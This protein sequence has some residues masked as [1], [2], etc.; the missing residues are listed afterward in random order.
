M[1]QLTK[2]FYTFLTSN[3]GVIILILFYHNFL[4]LVRSRIYIMLVKET[5]YFFPVAV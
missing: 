4:L 2:F 3:S 5:A 1:N